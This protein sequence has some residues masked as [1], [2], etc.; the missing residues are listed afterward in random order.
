MLTKPE[1]FIL[2]KA[3]WGVQ[4]Q[5]REPIA[6]VEISSIHQ[7]DVLREA[8]PIPVTPQHSKSHSGSFLLLGWT[9]SQALD[10][11]RRC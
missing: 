1:M 11:F 2:K 3:S 5:P 6:E 10:L 9:G 7:G 8:A 4:L